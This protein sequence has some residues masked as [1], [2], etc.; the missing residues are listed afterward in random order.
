MDSNSV[1][2][3]GGGGHCK[4]VIDSLYSMGYGSKDLLVL[5]HNLKINSEILGVK[6]VGTDEDLRNLYLLGIRK[7]FITVGSVGNTKAR[8]RIVDVFTQIG[9]DFVNVIDKSSNVASDVEI[10]KGVF[11]GK[12]SIVNSSTIIGNYCIV[13]SN[14]TIEHDCKIGDFSHVSPGAVL[15]GN[16][17]IGC[18]VHIGSNSSIREGVTIID[19]VIIGMGSIVLSNISKPGTYYGVVKENTK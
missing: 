14:T 4:S 9:F 7:A 19:D 5:D 3:V 8:E 16:V 15:N 1:V 10:G 17:K 12:G 11:I 18:R 13:N 6:V 2:L